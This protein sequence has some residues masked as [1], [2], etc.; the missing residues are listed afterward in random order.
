M[1]IDV[2]T[3]Q[4][5]RDIDIWTLFSTNSRRQKPRFSLAAARFSGFSCGQIL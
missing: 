3:V 2:V 4:S 1:T 5:L